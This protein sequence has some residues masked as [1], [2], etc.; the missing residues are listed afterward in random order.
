MLAYLDFRLV[1][2]INWST[3]IEREPTAMHWYGTSTNGNCTSIVPSLLWVPGIHK[4]L[5]VTDMSIIIVQC[6]SR[7]PALTINQGRMQEQREQT[8]LLWRVLSG[9]HR[10]RLGFSWWVSRWCARLWTEWI[11]YQHLIKTIDFNLW[12]ICEV[13]SYTTSRFRLGFFTLNW[14]SDLGNADSHWWIGNIWA[15]QSYQHGRLCRT[16]IRGRWRFRV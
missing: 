1:P 7:L 12:H 2:T 13:H 4:E 15:V 14:C 8:Y 16:C 5:L 10:E 6:I 11:L 3:P 9:I